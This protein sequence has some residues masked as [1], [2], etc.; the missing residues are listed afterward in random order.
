MLTLFATSIDFD[1]GFFQDPL[2]FTPDGTGLL[3][4]EG[5]SSSSVFLISGFPAVSAPEPT[6]LALLGLGLAGLGFM[7]RR[8]GER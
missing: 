8:S 5:E 3:Y 6:S 4:A 1:S 2:T 7:R